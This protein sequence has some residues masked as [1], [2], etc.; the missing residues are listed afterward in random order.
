MNA[1]VVR[2]VPKAVDEQAFLFAP[3]CTGV[4]RSGRVSKCQP[5]SLPYGVILEEYA[6]RR[7]EDLRKFSLCLLGRDPQ[8]PDHILWNEVRRQEQKLKLRKEELDKAVADPAVPEEKKKQVATAFAAAEKGLQEEV[9]NCIGQSLECLDRAYEVLENKKASGNADPAELDELQRK[10]QLADQPLKLLLHKMDGAA[11]CFSGGGIRSASFCL[12][13]LEALAR[14][15]VGK[16]CDA[17]QKEESRGLLHGLDYLSTVSGGGYLG[18]WLT[19]WIYRRCYAAVIQQRHELH[20]AYQQ[21]KEA[22]DSKQAEAITQ[23]ETLFGARKQELESAAGLAYKTCYRDVV[24]TLAGRAAATA[25]DPA[26]WPMRHLR[27]YTSYLA[28][29][30]G[31]TLDSW[32]LVAIVLRNLFIN[33]LMLTPLLFVAVA[34]PQVAYYAAQWF[35]DTLAESFLLRCL[36]F[37]AAVLLFLRAAV[38]AADNLPSHRKKTG[39]EKLRGHEG[40]GMAETLGNFAIPVLLANWLLVELWWSLNR[41]QQLLDWKSVALGVL[42]LAGLGIFFLCRGILKSDVRRLLQSEHSALTYGEAFTRRMVQFFLAGAAATA[43]ATGLAVWF[44]L[45]VLTKLANPPIAS[46]ANEW[47]LMTFGLP[48]VIL[49]PLLAISL[50]CGLLGVFEME[51]DREWWSRAGAVQLAA[52]T[53]WIAAFSLTLYGGALHYLSL[54]GSLG[55]G[56]A[57]GLLGAIGSALGFSSKT[58]PGPLPVKTEQLGKVGSFLQKYNLLLPAIC[59]LALLLLALG[60]ANGEVLLAEAMPWPGFLAHGLIFVIA[61][62][63]SFV[64]N[65]AISIN[66][67]SLNGLYR[68]RLMRAFLG[69]SNARRHADQFTG[70]DPHDTPIARDLPH[71]P[72]VPLH[73]INTTLN[74]VGT[75]NTA[76]RQRKAEPFS[77]S[78]LHSGSWRLGYVP[79]KYYAGADGP[80]LATTMTI[81]GAAFNPNM[82]YHSSP[83]VTLMMTFFNVRLGWWMPNPAREEG[84]RLPWSAKGADFLRRNGPSLALEPLIREAFGRTDDTYRWIELT[85][86][87]HFENL[88]LYEM[89]MRRCKKIVVVDAGADPKCQF[90]D[91]G[92]AI[93][94]IQIDLGIPICFRSLPFQEGAKPENRYCAVADIDYGCVD[95][96]LSSEEAR[97]TLIYIKPALTGNEPPDIKQYSLT[98]GDFPHEATANQFFNEAQFESYRHLGSFEVEEIVRNKCQELLSHSKQQPGKEAS[99]PLGVSFDSFVMAAENHTS[100]T[101]EKIAH[102]FE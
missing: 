85:D 74:L 87:G 95:N 10:C 96:G 16:L 35:A 42:I 77:F 86:G 34:L 39:D 13:V 72:G 92:N 67:F 11:L 68:M 48:L 30:L 40:P 52:T 49:I 41:D 99:T 43:L 71:A 1:T 46:G 37:A 15:S 8:S 20:D 94:K 24:D 38:F 59:G 22:R 27:Q 82:G 4:N 70:F 83:L 36:V 100:S 31:F 93:R 76:W 62:A 60:A 101:E 12:G 51:E 5:H 69:A 17:Q 53:V 97:G 33:W 65:R 2:N 57:G 25:G 102:A 50:L 55:F 64:I 58:S 90:E 91:L 19:A 26:P 18:G 89:V 45:G 81:S 47:P 9:W 29:S 61:L 75:K 32:T 88:G 14:F 23:A 21:L 63:L 73:V 54:A 80:T 56:G 84:G 3:A 79:T 98:H 66:L 7:P 78:P 6:Y 28:P 44:Y